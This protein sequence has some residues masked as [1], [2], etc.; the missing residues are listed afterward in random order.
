MQRSFPAGTRDGVRREPILPQYANLE[1]AGDEKTAAALAV[2]ER[3]SAILVL[4][5][6]GAGRDCNA[7]PILAESFADVSR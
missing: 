2:V 1:E 4:S 5:C 3:E 6:Y 7:R